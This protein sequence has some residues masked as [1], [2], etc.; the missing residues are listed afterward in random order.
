VIDVTF[1]R[2]IAAATI[3]GWKVLDG[4][5]SESASD[6]RYITFTLDPT[7]DLDDS[8]NDHSRGWS[9][10]QLNPAALS[11]HLANTTE[12]N[13]EE[14]TTASQAAEQLTKYLEAACDS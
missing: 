11:T 6:H 3:R 9:Y 4:A 8:V 10:R 12:P 13:F 14:D 7:P 2:L 1:S 5:E